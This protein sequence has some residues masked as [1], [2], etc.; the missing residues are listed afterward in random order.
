MKRLFPIREELLPCIRIVAEQ[1]VS[2]QEK[3]R[4]KPGAAA[5]L[6]YRGNVLE[7]LLFLF[8]DAIMPV[9]VNPPA[10]G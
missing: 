6:E 2:A 10:A 8:G 1:P 4:E 9:S 3:H 7:C 5:V